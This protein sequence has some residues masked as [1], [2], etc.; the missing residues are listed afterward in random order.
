MLKK[1]DQPQFYF[2]LC[3]L[4]KYMYIHWEFRHYGPMVLLT[5]VAHI[6]IPIAANAIQFDS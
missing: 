2:L 6:A 1:G 3:F 4:T 5:K